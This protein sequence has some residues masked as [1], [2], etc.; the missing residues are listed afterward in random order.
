[1]RTLGASQVEK[2][3]VS[4]AST[5]IRDNNIKNNMTNSGA[6]IVENATT[7]INNINNNPVPSPE[8]IVPEIKQ[9]NIHKADNN[10]ECE[11]CSA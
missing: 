9:Y 8:N 7:I 1:M 10:E 4:E 2:S 11:G 6:N 5:H 3:T